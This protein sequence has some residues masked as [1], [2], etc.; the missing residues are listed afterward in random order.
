MKVNPNV[1]NEEDYIQFDFNHT[2][3]NPVHNAPVELPRPVL[4]RPCPPRPCWP[5]R[6]CPPSPVLAP[7]HPVPPHPCP[8]P[9][10]SRF[11]HRICDM[12][13]QNRQPCHRQTPPL[14]LLYIRFMDTHNGRNSKNMMQ[15][16][17]LFI[18][19]ELFIQA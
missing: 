13:V 17:M 8:P 5:P 15:I 1:K 9:L 2:S 4:P 19:C 6:P 16:L 11:C 7:P 14:L 10:W 12:V 18:I 3:V